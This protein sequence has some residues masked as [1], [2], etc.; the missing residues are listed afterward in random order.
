MRGS[1]KMQEEN[2]ASVIYL[3]TSTEEQNPENQMKDCISVCPSKTYSVIE[4]KVSAWKE[5]KREGFEELKKQI[6]AK[7]FQ[8][9]VVWDLDRIYR[10]RKRLIEF[11]Q[12]CKVYNIKIHSYRQQWLESLNKIQPPFN[13]IMF[14]LM[15]QIMGWLAEEESTKRSD[16][17]KAAIRKKGNKTISY[18]GNKW[19]RK[20][21]STQ[22]V[23]KILS[24]NATGLSM[25]KISQELG[26]SVGVVH[27]VIHKNIMDNALEE[28]IFTAHSKN[29][30]LMKGGIQSNG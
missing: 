5:L 24:L 4:D 12:L 8:H 17:V 21:L 25:A 3:R 13:E 6:K 7:K 18:R 16:R 22:K 19:G 9:L 20:S 28:I 30:Q 2:T 29:S 14:D 26:V 15:L 10:N 11:F 27:K 1:N 23:N